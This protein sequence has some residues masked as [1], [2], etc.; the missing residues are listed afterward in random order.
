MPTRSCQGGA[1]QWKPELEKKLP[2][3]DKQ[4]RDLCTRLL[5]YDNVP[6]KQKTFVNFCK[7][8]LALNRQ[9]HLAEKMWDEVEVM[10]APAL[11]ARVAPC[12]G[13]DASQPQGRCGSKR[14]RFN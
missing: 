1:Y 14:D 12:Y 5:S 4:M 8:S 9:P 13:L 10:L 3:M 11:L 7:N 2:N 6:N